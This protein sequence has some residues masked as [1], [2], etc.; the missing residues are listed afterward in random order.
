MTL[1]LVSIRRI[2]DGIVP[3]ERVLFQ[4]EELIEEELVRP[5]LGPLAILEPLGA[6]AEAT[7]GPLLV[8]KPMAMTG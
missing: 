6:H 5:G 3:L 7:G 4:I 1:H 2:V 8:G